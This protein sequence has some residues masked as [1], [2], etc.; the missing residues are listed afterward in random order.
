MTQGNPEQ[1][2]AC[3]VHAPP[4]GTQAP[5]HALFTQGPPQQSA[6]VAHDVPAGT[7][8]EQ[9]L[10][11]S[12]QRGMPSASFRQQ[13]SGLSLHQL[14][15]GAP[16]GSQ[17]LFSALHDSVLGLQMLPGSRQAMP[18]SQRPNSWV[19]DAF[20]HVTGPLTGSG[21]PDHPQQSL[22]F[23]HIS[24]VGEQPDGGWQTRKPGAAPAGAQTREQHVPPQAGGLE[25]DDPQTVPFGRHCVAPGAA[26][27]SPQVPSAAPA[28]LTQLPPQQ[29]AF[30]AQTSPCCVQNDTSEQSPPLHSF[31][32]HS[33]FLVHE[34]PVVLHVVL[35]GL[36]VP[37]PLPSGAHVPPQHS[38]F[39]P[40]A[41]LSATH[42]LV[43]HWPPM[44]APVQHSG[45]AVQASPGALQSVTLSPQTPFAQLAVQQSALVAH[46]LPAALQSAPSAREPS[47][48]A[49]MN[50]P[51]E[52]SS[53]P[54]SASAP[55]VPSDSLPQPAVRFS[56]QPAAMVTSK[57]PYRYLFM[58]RPR[59]E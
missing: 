57:I 35:S 2:S 24:P 26:T 12:R 53:S 39:C 15:L 18:L 40:H 48:M 51:P 3:V 8:A 44:H 25:P 5:P 34:L 37:P 33:S 38:S 9:S 20:A 58:G 46:V 17:Q 49:S 30:T 31:E 23:R 4:V 27:A 22:S 42:C 6:L 32:Q 1:Q 55:V 14:E 16:F 54:L 36:H 56:V 10:A 13:L 11:L 28:C 52:P 59:H 41:W 50:A 19:G 7:G 29:S 47:T 43:E 21:A 45:P